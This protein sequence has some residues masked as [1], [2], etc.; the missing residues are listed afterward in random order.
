MNAA[1]SKLRHEFGLTAPA[2]AS[3]AE[4]APAESTAEAKAAEQA[5]T[6][7]TP[8]VETPALPVAE[9]S[10]VEKTAET[11]TEAKSEAAELAEAEAQLTE[12]HA[13]AMASKESSR[14]AEIKKRMEEIHQEMTGLSARLRENPPADEAKKIKEK[15]N[16]LFRESAELRREL[17]SL[18]KQTQAAEAAPATTAETIEPMPINEVGP[19]PEK[20]EAANEK[21]KGIREGIGSIAREVRAANGEVSDEVKNK[22]RDLSNSLFDLETSG[23]APV[24]LENVRE[25]LQ[26]L[27]QSLFYD[28]DPAERLKSL[29]VFFAENPDFDQEQPA[30]AEAGEEEYEYVVKRLGIPERPTLPEAGNFDALMNIEV[31]AFAIAEGDFEDFFDKENGS[32][33]KAA[34][35]DVDAGIRLREALILELS[36]SQ[37]KTNAERQL[38]AEK[39]NNLKEANRLVSLRKQQW[40]MQR[41]LHDSQKV[42]K[43]RYTEIAETQAELDEISRMLEENPNDGNLIKAVASLEMQLEHQSQEYQHF[44]A[45]MAK[46]AEKIEVLGA[47]I[48]AG[49]KTLHSAKEKTAQTAKQVALEKENASAA[50]YGVQGHGQVL[51]EAKLEAGVKSVSEAVGEGIS[52]GVSGLV[53]I[54]HGGKEGDMISAVHET[55][56]AP[57]KAANF[58]IEKVKKGSGA[59]SSSKKAA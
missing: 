13:E 58:V 35:E 34:L 59:S 9:A 37:P 22:L 17:D 27:T 12:I 45:W 8:A 5:P 15:R 11:S 46:Q 53:D 50:E 20:R 56:Q 25:Q 14:E 41:E 40:E 47:E 30:A 18:Q 6:A 48:A 3:A 38:V 39:I 36:K 16:A 31:S 2:E 44:L 54:L 51:A 55:L 21:L 28:D 33:Y 52:K 23:V 26:H 7:E 24:G 4:A 49:I 43:L 10:S 29:K 57:G 42:D 32:R 19:T 1:L